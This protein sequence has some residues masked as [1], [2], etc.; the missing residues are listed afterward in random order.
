MEM[1][2]ENLKE[3]AYWV[4]N[5]CQYKRKNAQNEFVIVARGKQEGRGA[6]GKVLSS[7]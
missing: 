7:R 3:N 5:T 4:H 2:E 1:G 6:T